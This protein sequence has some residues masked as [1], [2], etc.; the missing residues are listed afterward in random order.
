MHWFVLVEWGDEDALVQ[1][2]LKEEVL[3][4]AGRV[5]SNANGLPLQTIML[6]P[7]SIRYRMTFTENEELY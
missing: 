3:W 1:Q 6:A 2:Q 7:P 5:K 4:S